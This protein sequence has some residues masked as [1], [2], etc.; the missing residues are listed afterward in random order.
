MKARGFTL[1]ELMI[2]V[3]LFGVVAV[4]AAISLSNVRHAS[5]L[6]AFA[7]ALM[8]H[9]TTARR[10]AVQTGRTY[11]LD[12]RPNSVSF[13][14]Q[15]PANPGQRTCPSSAGLESSHRFD[16]G[17]D[18]T[19]MYYATDLDNPTLGS[20]PTRSAIGTGTALLL[21]PNG[22]CDSLPQTP[23]PDGFS[24]Y[25]QSASNAARRRLVAISPT[26]ARPRITDIW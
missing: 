9:V 16:A 3:V 6:D 19:V 15:D 25:L 26:A 5:D 20:R 22:S 7:R 2:V 1:A 12:L 23:V 24:I 21:L 8:N 14:Q 13:C 10:R 4:L 11:V 18:A 17:R